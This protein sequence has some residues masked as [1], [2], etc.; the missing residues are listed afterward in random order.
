MG[1]AAT[2]SAISEHRFPMSQLSSPQGPGWGLA[3][4][5]SRD[6]PGTAATSLCTPKPCSLGPRF[7]IH[8]RGGRVERGIQLGGWWVQGWGQEC[9]AGEYGGCGDGEEAGALRGERGAC[10]DTA[11]AWHSGGWSLFLLTPPTAPPRALLP[12][13]FRTSLAWPST[14]RLGPSGNSAEGRVRVPQRS[15]APCGGSTRVTGVGD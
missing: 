13:R 12:R 14:P 1:T 8:A 11:G 10:G 6:Q 9:Q 15:A 5:S 7:A 3:A 4:L 2:S